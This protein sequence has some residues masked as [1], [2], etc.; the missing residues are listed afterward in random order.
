ME[1]HENTPPKVFKES[2]T[3]FF[4]L[5]VAGGILG[6]V[7]W[8]QRGAW[9]SSPQKIEEKQEGASLENVAAEDQLLTSL[10]TKN[11]PGVVSIVV[12]K[13]ITRV[14]SGFPFFFL[15]P[16]PT[17]PSQKDTDTESDADQLQKVG[18]GSG[19]FVSPDG[20][21]VTNKHVVADESAEY[22]V[23]RAGDEKEYK[24]TVIARDPFN[25]VAF[26]KIEGDNFPA[27]QLGNSDTLQVG[28]TAIAIGNSLGEFANSVS[29]GIVSGKQRSLTAGNQYG[30]A[31]TLSGVIQTD[32]AINPGNSGGPLFNLRGEV[33]GVNVAVAQ[34]AENIGFA[35]PI[36]QIKLRLEQVQKTGRIEV[37]YLGVRYVMMTETLQK[38]IGVP[39]EYGALVLRGK[40]VTD[41]AVIPGSPA[42]KA[43]I[44]E[45]DVL[46][47]VDGQKITT[48]SGIT[49]VLIQHRVGDTIAL[50]LWRN[51]AEKTVSLVLEER[52]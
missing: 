48:E 26:L 36:N 24:A 47:K 7:L 13:N 43:G 10:V 1:P 23:N 42:A 6:S 49:E 35:L 30:E 17:Q 19:F 46:L 50:Q 31:E 20:I 12:K 4:L 45:G 21:I 18:S 51:G 44:Q 52:P 40:E 11:S 37:P 38:E 16:T 15:E 3:L 5:A 39:Y 32:A 14:P 9:F 33:I 29:R 8:E 34:G 2:K 25:D 41:F 27:L 22:F 28:E